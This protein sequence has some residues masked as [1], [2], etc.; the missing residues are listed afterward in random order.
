[1]PA[2]KRRATW[3]HKRTY[4]PKISRT[5]TRRKRFYRRRMQRRFKPRVQRNFGLVVP[6]MVLT[7]FKAC[8]SWN[9]AR[10]GASGTEAFMRFY[11]NNPYDPIV[12]VSTTKCTGFDDMMDIYKYGI[13]YGCKIS[14]RPVMPTNNADVILYACHDGSNGTNTSANLS[15]NQITEGRIAA[16]WR[17]VFSYIFSASSQMRKPFVVYADIKKLEH[18]RELEPNLYQFQKGQGPQTATISSIGLQCACSTTFDFAVRCFIQVTYYCKLFQKI[19]M[20]E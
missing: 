3:T 14:V 12:G 7:K 2:R 10:V 1:M 15:L 16:K 18:K 9:L 20:T 13:C 11:T 6:N 19:Q 17:L 8:D 4:R 5:N